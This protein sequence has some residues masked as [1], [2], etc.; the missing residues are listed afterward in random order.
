MA[1]DERED[2]RGNV[3]TDTILLPTA[4]DPTGAGYPRPE[5]ALAAASVASLV[6]EPGP[7]FEPVLQQLAADTRRLD[8]P[9]LAGAEQ[10]RG[11]ARD[12]LAMHDVL[13]ELS[14]PSAGQASDPNTR[15]FGLLLEQQQAHTRAQ[16]NAQAVTLASQ[17]FF[18]CSNSKPFSNRS[19]TDLRS[20]RHLRSYSSSANGEHNLT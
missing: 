2:I 19:K 7:V 1:D 12:P 5:S 6:A 14:S 17:P 20:T 13:R 10:G 3:V 16:Q 15:L 18:S 11:A 8:N 4:R 9:V